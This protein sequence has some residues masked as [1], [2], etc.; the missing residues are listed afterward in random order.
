[1]IY[2]IGYQGLTINRMIETLKEYKVLWLVDVRSKP[3]SRN[4]SFRGPALEKR[5]T[6]DGL[7]YLWLGDKL[8]GFSAIQNRDIRVLAEWQKDKTVCIMC[9]EAVPHPN[10][11]HRHYEIALRLKAYGVQVLHIIPQ[12]EDEIIVGA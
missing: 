12:G 4:A 10:G 9:M 5:I 8:G 1:M 7:R 6:H 3:S 11:C 2:S